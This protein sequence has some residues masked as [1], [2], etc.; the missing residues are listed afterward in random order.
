MLYISYVLALHRSRDRSFRK[1]IKKTCVNNASFFT[2]TF[3]FAQTHDVLC[4]LKSVTR[5]ELYCFLVSSGRCSD[6]I[7]PNP[8]AAAGR[9]QH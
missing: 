9:R 8:A 3:R 5:I 6:A 1:Y 7:D 4:V 2:Q